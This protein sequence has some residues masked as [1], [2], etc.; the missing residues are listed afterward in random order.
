MK[1]IMLLLI[2]AAFTVWAAGAYAGQANT[3]DITIESDVED[4]ENTASGINSKAETNIH[5]VNVKEGKTGDI[6]IKG[7]AEDIENTASG[8]NSKAETNVGSVKVGD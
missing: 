5:S 7:K 3:G 8:F 4:V 1:K 2:V 6:V